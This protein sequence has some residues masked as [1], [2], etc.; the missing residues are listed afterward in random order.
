MDRIEK[1][2]ESDEASELKDSLMKIGDAEIP[3]EVKDKIMDRSG[4]MWDKLTQVC[5]IDRR[6]GSGVTC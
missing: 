2:I 5:A 6:R 3:Q 4:K 1:F